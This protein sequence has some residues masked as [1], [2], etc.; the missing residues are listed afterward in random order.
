MGCYSPTP[1]VPQSLVDEIIA[2]VHR[3]VVNE[4]ARRDMPFRGCLYAGLM[5]TPDGP[6]VLEFNVRFGDP[7]TQV[8]VPRLEG[9]LLDALHR[10]ATGALDG[11]AIGVSPRSCVT[12]VMAAP[13]YPDTPEDGIPIGGVDAAGALEDVMVFHAGTATAGGRLVSAGGRVLNVTALG[14]DIA[15]ARRRA[16]AGVDAID[17]PG[18]QHRSDIG[19]AAAVEQHA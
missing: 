10:S 3:P 11:A 18:E 16:Y 5:L 14:D 6:R 15:H 13:G 8:L 4:L 2:T 12:V 1:D 7:E 17:F 19:A 9:D